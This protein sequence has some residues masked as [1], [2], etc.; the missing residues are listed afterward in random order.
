MEA[1]L[2]RAGLTTSTEKENSQ[3]S[4]SLLTM[5]RS[6]GSTQSQVSRA[7]YHRLSAVTRYSKK[8]KLILEQ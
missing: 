5:T 2:T 1:F 3:T 7:G 6:G 4:P 8:E